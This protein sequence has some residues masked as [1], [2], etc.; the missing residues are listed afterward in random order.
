MAGQG[1]EIGS[2]GSLGGP[3]P[4]GAT[5]GKRTKGVEIASEGPQPGTSYYYRVVASNVDGTAEG[6]IL[7]FTT[8]TLPAVI[9]SPG[10][11]PLIA[12]PEIGFP[13]EEVVAKPLTNKQK[14]AK[15]LKGCRKKPKSKGRQCERQA[16]ERYARVKKQKR[17]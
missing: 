5:G 11:T 17:A 7:S 8:S 3:K 10:R 2:D 16:R 4:F 6:A 13:F 1:L 14:L 9:A 15:A 12:V